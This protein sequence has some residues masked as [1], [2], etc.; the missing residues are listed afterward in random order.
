MT[1]PTLAPASA[2]PAEPDP[3]GPDPVT[4][5]GR[6]GPVG[7][8]RVPTPPLAPPY[9]D[10]RVEGDG[11]GRSGGWDGR[12]W[13]GSPGIAGQLPFP[14]PSAAVPRLR[15]AASPQPSTPAGRLAPPAAWSARFVRV[16]LEALAGLRPLA[17]L[18][19]WAE[20]NVCRGISRRVNAIERCR[21]LPRTIGDLRSL[22]VSSPAGGVAEICAVVHI[23]HRIRAMALRVEA[24]DGQ[25]RCTHLTIG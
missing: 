21:D 12:R 24:T 16:L 20:P 25:W 15:L 6:S 22:H 4:G 14:T 9:D 19:A 3:V 10:E 18:A 7:V 1:A 8:R 23:G 13:I 11:E 17:Q 2:R 5:R